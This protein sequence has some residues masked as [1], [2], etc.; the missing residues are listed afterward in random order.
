MITFKTETFSCKSNSNITHCCVS[1]RGMGLIVV[2]DN[3]YLYY[4]S[5]KQFCEPRE[6]ADL[7][8]NFDPTNIADQYSQLEFDDNDDEKKE[9]PKEGNKT[10]FYVKSIKWSPCDRRIGILYYFKDSKGNE[11]NA[12]FASI[13][14]YDFS[15]TYRLG[16]IT[17][18]HTVNPL[19]ITFRNHFK[20][21]ALIAICWSNAFISQ[22]HLCFGTKFT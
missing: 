17:H 18:P 10:S 7:Y 22:H 19:Q 1:E 2:A 11:I 13:W 5:L 8:L 21:G 12:N 4:I 20:F 14:A 9:N 16:F 6:L 3:R 15:T